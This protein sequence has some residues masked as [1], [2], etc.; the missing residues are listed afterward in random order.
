M[1]VT[2]RIRGPQIAPLRRSL[3]LAAERLTQARSTLF[4]RGAAAVTEEE[5]RLILLTVRRTLHSLAIAGPILG[6]QPCPR[7]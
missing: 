4:P 2:E 3:P 6:A 5:P 7:R 1:W